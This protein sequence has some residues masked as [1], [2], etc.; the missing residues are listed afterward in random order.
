MLFGI[1]NTM[2]RQVNKILTHAPSM[3]LAP[4]PL[5][6]FF[7]FLMLVNNQAKLSILIYYSDFLSVWR[8]SFMKK[9]QYVEQ[10]STHLSL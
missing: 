9:N 2:D 1:I 7:L 10:L 3:E 5:C 8:E 4:F 6:I